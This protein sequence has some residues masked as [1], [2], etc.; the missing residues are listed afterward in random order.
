LTRL[1]DDLLDISRITRGKI[2]LRKEPLAVADIVQR[3]VETSR[4]VIDSRRHELTVHVPPE[5]LLIEGDLIRLVQ[6]VSNLLNNAA[7]YTDVGG[8]IGLSAG[9][10][11]AEVAI[12]VRDTGRGLDAEELDRVFDLFYQTDPTIDRS[13]GGLGVGLALVHRLMELHGGTVLAS[14]AGRGQG[15]EF[16]IRL[17]RL[18]NPPAAASVVSAMVPVSGLRILVVDDNRDAVD[19]LAVLLESDG[20]T[21]RRAY[22]GETAL[23]MAL[24]EPP[25]V[26]LLDLGLPGMDGYAVARAVRRSTELNGVWLLA[27]TGYGQTND[28]E[29]TRAAGFDGHLLKPLAF[30][31]LRDALAEYRVHDG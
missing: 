17:P 6:V 14:S 3:A 23:T 21:V 11:G 30:K 13:E 4:P 24:A 2:E 15:T 1:V 22:D 7:K 18:P 12:R 19:S 31:A 26:I 27:L 25:Q 8:R 28:R 5:P 29:K 20:H 10:D 16:V 9:C